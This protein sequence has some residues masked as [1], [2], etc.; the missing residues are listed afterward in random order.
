[1]KIPL[2]HE[3]RLKRI[4]SKCKRIGQCDVWQGCTV[5]NGYPVISYL[6]KSYRGHRLVYFLHKGE[7]PDG[8]FVLHK[9]DNR[10]CLRIEHLWTGTAQQNMDD[11]IRK[12][13]SAVAPM[14]THCKH[15]HLLAGENLLVVISGKYQARKCVTCLKGFNLKAWR[16]RQAKKR[17]LAKEKC[18]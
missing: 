11:K 13:R 10:R 15:G 4:I 14:P 17:L 9:C 1:M 6:N 18:E 3:E 2:S 16:A 8:L 7:I 12:G 5:A